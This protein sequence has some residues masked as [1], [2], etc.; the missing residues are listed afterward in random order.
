MNALLRETRAIVTE[1]PGTTR[2]TIEESV[3]IGSIPVRLTDTARIR[4][5][6]GKIEQIGI[7]RSWE[8]IEGADL[9]VLLLDVSRGLE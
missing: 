5:T 1:I 2:D 8:S 7:K 9:V 3:N 6:E 4:D